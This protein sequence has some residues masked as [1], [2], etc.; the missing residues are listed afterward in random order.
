M[1]FFSRLKN[2]SL[3]GGR[4][5]SGAANLRQFKNWNPSYGSPDGEVLNDLPKLRARARDLHKN[6][7][8]ARAAEETIIRNVVGKGLIMQTAVDYDTLSD[9]LNL[10]LEEVEKIA[11]KFEREIET[12]WWN[13][14]N[15]TEADSR[16]VSDGAELTRL[17][18]SSVLQSGDVFATFSRRA[19]KVRLG[20]IEA[21]RVQNPYGRASTGTLRDGVELDDAGAPIGY[22]VNL[23][24]E[25]WPEQSV[26]IPRTG[27]ESGRRLLLHLLRVERP[28]QTRGIPWAAPVIEELKNLNAYEK[29]ELTAALVSSYLTFFVKKPPGSIGSMLPDAASAEEQELGP[30]FRAGP[31]AILELPAGYDVTAHNPARPN[32]GAVPFVEATLKKIGTALGVPFEILVAHYTTSFTS[33]RA[34][35]IEFWKS[36]TTWRSWLTENFMRA[37]Y[38][39]FLTDA[40]LS[41]QVEAPGFFESEKIRRAWSAQNWFGPALGQINEKVETDAVLATVALG[42]KSATAAFAEAYGTDYEDTIRA[43]KREQK[44]REKHGVRLSIDDSTRPLTQQGEQYELFDTQPEA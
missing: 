32:S 44:I 41:G 8:I 33:A 11:A 28:G 14:Y 2:F 10:P 12:L 22:H 20:L 4:G 39:E 1:S 34:A 5:F 37:W 19:G 30:D 25:Q 3:R 35:R 18:L 42:G 13:Y 29:S 31:A 24:T 15:T 27:A 17:V 43:L 26:F 38:E 21:D 23:N 9:E 6:N 7:S 16:G 36:V 40:V